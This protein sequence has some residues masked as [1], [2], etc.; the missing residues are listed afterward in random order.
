LHFNANYKVQGLSALSC[1]KMAE[2]VEMQ[3]GLLS[4]MGPGNMHYMGM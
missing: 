3:F 1:E 4:L 2:P